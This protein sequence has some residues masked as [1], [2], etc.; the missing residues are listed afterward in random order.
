[1]HL[2]AFFRSK[3]CFAE[4]FPDPFRRDNA[5][6]AT[7]FRKYQ[8]KLLATIAAGMV[9]DSQSVADNVGKFDKKVLRRQ[10]AA[11]QLG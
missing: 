5:L 11:G 4:L 9:S 3:N 8:D 6:L 7:C 2:L 1:M 10:F